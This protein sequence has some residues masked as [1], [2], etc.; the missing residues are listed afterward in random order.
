MNLRADLDK[1][2]GQIAKKAAQDVTT[3]QESVDALKALTPYY[4]LTQKLALKGSDSDEAN[5]ATFEDFSAQIAEPQEERV[6]GHGAK[7]RSR[8][9]DA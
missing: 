1:L 7:V 2:A 3:L 6:N 4:A 9:R 8:K 5:G